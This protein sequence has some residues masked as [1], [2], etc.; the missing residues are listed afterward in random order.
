VTY[1]ANARRE[2]IRELA[3]VR[4]R[5][6]AAGD[7]LTGTE[8]ALKE[9]EARFAA[10]DERV[11]A[12]ENARHATCAGREA[13][14]PVRYAARQAHQRAGAMVERLQR[15]VSETVGRLGRMA[16]CPDMT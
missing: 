6:E 13:A 16:V 14:R 7:A 2:A 11:A 10:A 1:R 4:A 8:A 3:E 12:A 5:L 15:C 9:A